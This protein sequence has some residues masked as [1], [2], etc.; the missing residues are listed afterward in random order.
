M[1]RRAADRVR[2]LLAL[3]GPLD[4]GSRVLLLRLLGRFGWKAVVGGAAIVVYAAVRYRTWI[5]WMLLVWCAA[6]WMHT[7]ATATEAAEE[8][9]DEAGKQP[10]I[11]PLP[12]LMWK[13]IG[14]APG[15]HVKTL[16]ELLQAAAPEETVD[17]AAVRAKLAA[18]GIP[19]RPSVR[20]AAGRVNEGV[21]RDDLKAWE[22]ARF[23]A[24]PV[25]L[26]KARS[27][28]VATALTSDV[29]NPPTGVATPPTPG[30]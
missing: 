10:P 9:L 13:H 28:P 23:P 1:V 5:A 14:E 27:S 30:E 2:A 7:P 22:E 6:A 3:L 11:D 25:P 26:S 20:D 17:R 18:R 24:P 12:W 19:V 4:A 8:Q 21:H 29:A 16:A 15:V